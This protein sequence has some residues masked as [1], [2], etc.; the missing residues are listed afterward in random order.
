MIDLAEIW[1]VFTLLAPSE[2]AR[3]ME[4]D[5]SPRVERACGEVK[6]RR[7]DGIELDWGATT[8]AAQIATMSSASD[9]KQFYIA[10]LK[11][12]YAYNISRL[13]EAYGLESTSFTDLTENDFSKVDRTRAAVKE[14]DRLF[15]I[16][17][18]A[19]IKQKV[20]ELFQRCS[21]SAKTAWKRNRT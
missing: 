18:S 4:I 12:R 11:D 14:D 2:G 13:N 17:L 5:F 3:V 10:W 6:S 8:G 15:L 9:G 7:A 16:D 1:F 21:P 19:T 20:D